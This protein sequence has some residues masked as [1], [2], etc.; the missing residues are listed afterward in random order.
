MKRFAGRVAIAALAVLAAQG[1]PCEEQQAALTAETIDAWAT[2]LSNAGRWGEDDELGTLNLITPAVRVAAA[3]LVTDGVSVSMAHPLLTDRSADNWMPFEHRM[4]ATP[5]RAGGWATDTWSLM[6]HGFAHSHIDALCHLAHKGKYYNGFPMS[7][8]TDEGCK[9]LGVTNI[10]DGIFTRGVLMD[11]PRL[12]GK[13]WLDPGEAVMV[14]DL[15][16]WEKQAGIKVGSGDAILLHT[17]RWL[18]RAE[19]GPTQGAYAGFHAST[20]PWLK[21]RDVAVV[22]T[23]GG[24]DVYPSGIPESGAPVHTLV[25]TALGM[26]ILDVMDLTEV[27]AAAAERK[28][29]TF[30]LTAAPLRVP[31]GTGSAINAIATF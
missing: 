1:A 20:V 19:E 27:S 11:I 7:E 3:K 4:Q 25:L 26:P 13:A 16:A 30:L 15:E 8:T 12:K 23:D 17:G 31:N 6:F 10:G 14:A 28:R 21:A 18:R 2:D 9:K 24:L 5:E 29:W 22:G